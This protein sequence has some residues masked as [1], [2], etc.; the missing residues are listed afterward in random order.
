[1]LE[2]PYKELT[3]PGELYKSKGVTRIRTG[4]GN[5]YN[6]FYTLEE[7]VKDYVQNYLNGY[8]YF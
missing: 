5:E 4:A 6:T 7:G 1:M 8:R 2:Y 3:L